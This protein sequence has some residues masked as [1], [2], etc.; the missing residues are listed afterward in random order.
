MLRIVYPDL[1]VLREEHLAMTQR[2]LTIYSRHAAAPAD[3][4][5]HQPRQI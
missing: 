2:R 5:S 3:C 4:R 1:V